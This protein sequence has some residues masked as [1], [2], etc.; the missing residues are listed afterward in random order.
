MSISLCDS[1]ERIPR[2]REIHLKYRSQRMPIHEQ[3]DLDTSQINAPSD[4]L[5]LARNQFL[6]VDSYT[7]DEASTMFLT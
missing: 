3:F 5:V 6:S 1:F 2:Q 4:G 7:V